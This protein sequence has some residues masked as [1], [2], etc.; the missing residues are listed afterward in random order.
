MAILYTNVEMRARLLATGIDELLDA[1]PPL[2]LSTKG[3]GPCLIPISLPG[4]VPSIRTGGAV[5]GSTG[6]DKTTCCSQFGS[7]RSIADGLGS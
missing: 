1:P 6:I 3:K 5:G 4:M 2:S 7:A